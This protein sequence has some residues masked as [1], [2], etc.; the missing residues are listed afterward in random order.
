VQTVAAV[1]WSGNVSAECKYKLQQANSL[2]IKVKLH[3]GL[4]YII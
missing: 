4:S 1:I 3:Y 2:K